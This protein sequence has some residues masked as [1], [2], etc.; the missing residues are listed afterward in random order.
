[1]NINKQIVYEQ[2]GISWGIQNLSLS[3]PGSS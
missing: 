3:E 2:S 1:M